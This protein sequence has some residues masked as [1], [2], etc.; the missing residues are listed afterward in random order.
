MIHSLNLHFPLR[1]PIRYRIQLEYYK[2]I[3]NNDELPNTLILNL[4]YLAFLREELNLK[5][6]VELSKYG[7]MNILIIEKDIIT[8][9]KVI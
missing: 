5:P 3:I 1:Y 6:E 9:N 2:F 8:C 4:N 7:D